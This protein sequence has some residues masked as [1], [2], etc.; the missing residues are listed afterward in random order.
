[1]DLLLSG[2]AM[3]ALYL[4]LLFGACFGGVV[5]FRW[6]SLRSREERERALRE[7]WEREQEQT[8]APPPAP[9]AASPQKIYYIVEKKRTRSKAEYGEPREIHF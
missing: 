5:G 6:Y 3:G 7:E 2:A 9:K 4:L 1:M 8:P